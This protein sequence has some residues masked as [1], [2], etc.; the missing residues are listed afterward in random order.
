[1]VLEDGGDEDEAIA[2][3]LH[4]AVEDQGG[5]DTLKEIQN[6]FGNR[7]ADIVKGCTDSYVMPKPPWKKRKQDFIDSIRTADEST[8][9]VA[10]ADK[11]YNGRATLRDIRNEG[12]SGWKKFTGGKTGT[13]WY[14]RQ[15]TDVFESFGPSILLDELKRIISDLENISV[16]S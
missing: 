4:D 1:L 11:V 12:E 3:L 10:L 5:L 2:A 9:R 6:R 16:E 14:Y 7:V 13:L 15:L 8:R